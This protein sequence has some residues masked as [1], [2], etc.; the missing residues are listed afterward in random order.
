MGSIF[1]II[2]GIIIIGGIIKSAV[3]INI[4]IKRWIKYDSLC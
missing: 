1:N 4:I 3:G 2:I